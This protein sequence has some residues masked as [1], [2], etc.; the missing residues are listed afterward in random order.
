MKKKGLKEKVFSGLFWKLSERLGAQLVTFVVSIVLARILSPSD[1]GAI[2]MITIFITIANVFVESSFGKSLIQ[3][4]DADNIDFS[5]IF[6]FNMV[7]SIIMYLIVFFTAPLVAKF[8]NMEILCPTMRV[9]GIKLILAGIN[10]V[11]QAYVSRHMIFKKF[12]F[13]TII[14]TIISAFVGI[15]MAYHGFGVWALVGQYLTNSFMDTLILW[16]TVKWRPT[17]EFSFKRLKKLFG[18][19]WKI[20]LSDLID[21]VYNDLR[22]FI[23]GKKYTSEDLAFYNKGKSFP[24]LVL[25][26]VNIAIASVLFPAM[27]SIQENKE[28]VKNATRKSIR[29]S[30]YI[31]FPI[32]IGLVVTAKNLVIVLLTEKWV[33]CVIYLQIACIYLSFVPL[34]NANTQAINALGRSDITLRIEITKKVIGL[35]LILFVMN[36]GVLAIALSSIVSSFVGGFVNAY[37]NKKLLNYSYF[38]QMKDLGKNLLISLIMGGIIF[39]IG[40][41]PINKLLLLFIQVISGIIIYL[42]LSI[43]TKNEEFSFVIDLLKSYKVK[44]TNKAKS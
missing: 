18:F 3:K 20:L 36:W 44:F 1:Y 15:W 38:S 6:Y 13:S 11:Q 41:L 9:L 42:V 32:M 40:F 2:A 27:S 43:I 22:S 7:F 21:T 14:G 23:I 37:P 19:G 28:Q 17:L 29:I 8:Y 5:T 39:C 16:F 34:Y 4:K 10:S 26:N 30:S 25:N 12:F 35:S 33:D 31:I 24:S